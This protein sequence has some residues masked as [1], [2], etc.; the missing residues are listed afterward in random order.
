MS[1]A[2]QEFVLIILHM[3]IKAFSATY[4][5]TGI[6]GHELK[7]SLSLSY[8]RCVAVASLPVYFGHGRSKVLQVPSHPQKLSFLSA[9]YRT[10]PFT[11]LQAQSNNKPLSSGSGR[12]KSNSFKIKHHIHSI[13][14]QILIIF[15][16]LQNPPAFQFKIQLGKAKV[17]HLPEPPCYAYCLQLITPVK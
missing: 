13:Q 15:S 6:R 5:A 1:P 12:Q 4:L 10:T 2:H 3:E 16:N 17:T 11:A 7:V 14:L 8:L 9:A